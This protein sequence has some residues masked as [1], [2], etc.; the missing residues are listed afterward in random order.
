MDSSSFYDTSARDAQYTSGRLES[1]SAFQYY[2]RLAPRRNGMFNSNSGNALLNMRD[3]NLTS[4]R[5]EAVS[6]ASQTYGGACSVESAFQGDSDEMTG[7]G[8][9]CLETLMD[10]SCSQCLGTNCVFI[11]S[12][13]DNLSC[14]NCNE[15]SLSPH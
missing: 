1:D 15:N 10:C 7:T 12:G 11:S 8:D 14:T 9:P 3:Q 6:Y 4:K 13:K 2:T 5:G